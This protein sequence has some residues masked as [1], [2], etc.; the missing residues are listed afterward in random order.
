MKARGR[1]RWQV[2]R[3]A[4]VLRGKVR[5][6]AW[7]EGRL[8]P[9]RE[10]AEELGVSVLTLRAAQTLLARDRLLEIRHGSG[11]YVG[12]RSLPRWVGI[13]TAFNILQP[14]ASSF[15]SRVPHELGRFLEMNGVRTEVYVGNPMLRES[16]PPSACARLV[17]DAEG[18]RLDALAILSCPPTQAWQEWIASLPIPVVGGHTPFR[19][20]AGYPDL[21]RRAVRRLH[22]QGSR[23]IAML[24]WAGD[25]LRDPLREALS[26]CG[27]EYRPEWVRSNLDPKL[28]G[29]GWEEFR[30]V[31]FARPEKPDGILVMDDVLFV[32]AC[33][34][35]QELGIAVPR[36]L[37]IVAH[38]N[39]GAD[40]RYP[41]PVTEALVDPERYAGEMGGLLLKRLRG[42]RVEQPMPVIPIEL[43][44]TRPAAAPVTQRLAP[45][46]TAEGADG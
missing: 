37:K 26:D 1:R 23:R 8:P 14:R 5:A 22:E 10:L 18:G 36:Q 7:P 2:E 39:K 40:R 20:D 34:A 31:W 24:S 33:V 9:V 29:A 28:S 25:G 43:V 19:V 4:E 30:E 32:E 16:D 42:E 21:V 13:F 38:A 17:S 46:E 27:L 35:I 44:G 3:V 11:V 45:H 41:F 12:E 15:H 6:A